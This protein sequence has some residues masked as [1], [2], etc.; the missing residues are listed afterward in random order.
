MNTAFAIG[1]FVIMGPVTIALGQQPQNPSP[2]VEHT[3]AHLR[4]KEETSAGRREKL[5]LG[6]L[7][8]PERQKPRT[9]LVFFHGGTW[10]PEVAAARNHLA[11][12]TVQAGAGSG[13]Y[14]KLFE[15]P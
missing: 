1:L 5:E 6:T 13:V 10:L 2:M 11:A 15:D 12:V 7:F 9:V 4:L 8:V 3:R 14:A